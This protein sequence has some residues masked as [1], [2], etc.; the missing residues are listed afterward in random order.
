MLWSQLQC[1]QLLHCLSVLVSAALLLPPFEE[2]PHP[3][4]AVAA[5]VHA[6]VIATNF[7]FILK[8]SRLFSGNVSSSYASII[9]LFHNKCKRILSFIVIF[10]INT[11]F[12]LSFLCNITPFSCYSHGFVVSW[13]EKERTCYEYHRNK[14]S[15][16]S[17]TDSLMEAGNCFLLS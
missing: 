8:S 14:K 10:V 13:I 6:M 12:I 9:E 4:S 3:V 16:C 2:P 17:Q 7:L 11:N 1:Y 15:A 5:S